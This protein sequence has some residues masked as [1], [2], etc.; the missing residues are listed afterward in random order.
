[1]A[2]VLSGLGGRQDSEQEVP[3]LTGFLKMAG[4]G[5]PANSLLGVV[6]EVDREVAPPP[7]VV[8][9]EVMVAVG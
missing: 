7:T 1:M 2:L 3:D 9:P 8:A 5:G 4:A 6:L